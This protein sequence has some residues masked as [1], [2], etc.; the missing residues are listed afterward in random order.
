VI[1][2]TAELQA[3]MPL[4]LF[5]GTEME[6][7]ASVI[8]DGLQGE[9]EAYLGRPLETRTITETPRYDAGFQGLLLSYTPVLSITSVTADGSLIPASSYVVRSW[10]LDQW[11]PY[12]CLSVTYR[13]GLLETK[14]QTVAP[15]R[16]LILQ[17][18][19]RAM[20]KLLADQVGLGEVGVDGGTAL[21]W[22]DDNVSGRNEG[23]F[24]D[25]ELE[26]VSRWKRR[27]GTV[28]GSTCTPPPIW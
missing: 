14:P 12:G 18:A 16:R 17:A 2:S 20:A 7:A 9:V 4:H 27:T 1:V 23:S 22:L 24:A 8:L 5:M 28:M 15:I 10:G 19:K 25:S 3:S 11:W 6:T 13:A 26:R 21:R